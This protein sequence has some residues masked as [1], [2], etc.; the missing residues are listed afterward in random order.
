M[1]T[2]RFKPAGADPH[3]TYYHLV[4]RIAGLPGEFPFGDVEKEMF[5]RLIKKLAGFYT[6]DVLAWQVMGNHFHIIVFSPAESPSSEEA[7]RRFEAYHNG[8]KVLDPTSPSCLELTGRLRDIS[9][10]MH[11]LQQ[12]FT[13]WYNRTRPGRRRG[14]LWAERFKSVVLEGSTAVWECIKYVELN[15]VRAGVVRDP[16]DYR[17]GSWGEWNGAGAHPYAETLIRHLHYNLGEHTRDWTLNDF[18]CEFRKEMARISTAEA[19]GTT[20][21]IEAA[22]AVAAAGPAPL[23][24]LNRRVRHWSDGLIIGTR[25]FI[26]NN[27]SRVLPSERLD[28]HQYPLAIRSARAAEAGQSFAPIYAWRRLRPV[29]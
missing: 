10:F 27:L 13:C 3:G 16:A 6:L 24:T 29:E 9:W 26:R 21:Q 2:A 5:I 23:L 15:C 20:A 12:Q 4:N 14:I 7:A 25:I 19:H 18:Y 8:K 28:R 17:F 1:R 11:D 22:V